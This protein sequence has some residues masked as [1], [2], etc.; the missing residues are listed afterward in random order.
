MTAL[1]LQQLRRTGVEL[2][3]QVQVRGCLT[4]TQQQQSTE[5]WKAG[6]IQRVKAEAEALTARRAAEE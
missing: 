6:T 1:R 5:T 3:D 4:R 2:T